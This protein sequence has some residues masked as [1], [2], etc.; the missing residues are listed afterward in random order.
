M[1]QGKEAPDRRVPDTLQAMEIWKDMRIIYEN[2][3]IRSFYL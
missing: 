1:A 3:V 2:T